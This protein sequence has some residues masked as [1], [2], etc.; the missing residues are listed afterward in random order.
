[1]KR[2]I[3]KPLL[4]CLPRLFLTLL[5][6]TLAFIPTYE[7]SAQTWDFDDDCPTGSNPGQVADGCFPGWIN[8]HGS[9][10]QA[11]AGY[12]NM[13]AWRTDCSSG[14]TIAGEGVAL[15]IPEGVAGCDYRISFDYRVLLAQSSDAIAEIY[16]ISDPFSNVSTTGSL[17]SSIYQIPDPPPS[18]TR[19]WHKTTTNSSWETHTINAAEIPSGT[20]QLWFR[21][22]IGVVF[23]GNITSRFYLDNVDI[24]ADCPPVCDDLIPILDQRQSSICTDEG[25]YGFASLSF[26]P[27]DGPLT[28]DWTYSSTNTTQ[29]ISNSSSTVIYRAGP[30]FHLLEVT[31]EDGCSYDYGYYFVN[32]CCEKKSA[33]NEATNDFFNEENDGVTVAPNPFRGTTRLTGLRSFDKSKKGIRLTLADQ[34]GREVMNQPLSPETNEFEIDLTNE[35][36]GIYYLIL[37]SESDIVTKK[38]VKQ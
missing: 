24:K 38:I 22:K 2:L 9:S 33:K 21:V 14:S 23:G 11:S 25:R 13:T 37:T 3:T 4:F 29:D 30:G 20:V 28:F 5:T 31:K 32:I 34:L 10:N 12:I 19:I 6:L 16:A 15:N 35:K 36:P 27:A 1:M 7:V 17:C 26:D 8:T 18:S